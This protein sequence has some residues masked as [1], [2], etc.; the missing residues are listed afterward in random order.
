MIRAG[1]SAPTLGARAVLGLAVE[2]LTRAAQSGA[3]GR[4]AQLAERAVSQLAAPLVDPAM[5]PSGALLAQ[6]HLA[7]QGFP[8][9]VV[10]AGV[11]DFIL[12]GEA[13]APVDVLTPAPVAVARAAQSLC[14][15][16]R[17]RS[18]EGDA[19]YLATYLG[20]SDFT[21]CALA[22][23][24]LDGSVVDPHG[25]VADARSRRLATVESPGPKL[26]RQPAT[27]VRALRLAATHD[28]VLSAQFDSAVDALTVRLCRAGVE[29][30][31]RRRLCAE[32]FRAVRLEP[33]SCGAFLR[34]LAEERTSPEGVGSVLG[35]ALPLVAAALRDH[36]SSVPGMGGYDVRVPDELRERQYAW[37]NAVAD[38]QF[39]KRTVRAVALVLPAVTRH[40]RP[41]DAD[42]AAAL[43]GVFADSRCLSSNQAE[44]A[45]RA[46]GL[47]AETSRVQGSFRSIQAAVLRVGLEAVRTWA[48][49]LDSRD[50]ALRS[51]TGEV[52]TGITRAEALSATVVEHP[53][54][55]LREEDTLL[56]SGG[57]G[58]GAHAPAESPPQE[59]EPSAPEQ[60]APNSPAEETPRSDDTQRIVLLGLGEGCDEPH[61]DTEPEEDPDAEVEGSGE[62]DLLCLAE[63]QLEAAVCAELPPNGPVIQQLRAYVSAETLAN[64]PET[65]REAARDLCVTHGVVPPV[66]LRTAGEQ[67]LCLLVEDEAVRAKVRRRVYWQV[68]TREVQDEDKA[69]EEAVLSAAEKL[70]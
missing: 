46:L 6:Q 55:N 11:R 21:V 56:P 67:A 66:G 51:Q 38:L 3:L 50:Q 45:M 12:L 59:P 28:L 57:V 2:T 14:S 23:S 53:P 48:A 65:L 36:E 19:D 15:P 42:L 1:V 64:D 26:T 63:S 31:Y 30:D 24:L 4:S 40:D 49:V 61:P 25:A 9:F 32:V 47:A 62:D 68:R 17:V 10:G 44:E 20:Q 58:G 70:S 18:F 16:T 69:V 60:P 43:R 54:Q 8:S 33:E 41:V 34:L 7:A 22:V 39:D 29:P 27:A 13:R 35:F 37:S 52:F 5:F